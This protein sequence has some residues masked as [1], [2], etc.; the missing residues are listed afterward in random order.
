MDSCAAALLA[1]GKSSRMGEDK[2]SLRLGNRTL[3]Q[4]MSHLLNRA[5]LEKIYI[6]RSD[7]IPDEFPGHGPLSGVHAVLHHAMEHHTHL[8]FV[9][10]D[11]PCLTSA[12]IGGLMNAPS[13]NA[14]VHYTSYPMPFR[15]AVKEQWY[16]LADR[17][18]HRAKDVS[19]KYFQS[20]I[21]N[22]LVLPVDDSDAHAFH[23]INTSEEWRAFKKGEVL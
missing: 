20:Q 17:L 13:D 18:L 12:L 23:N 22:T 21:E 11:M 5:G 9:P 14:L 8:I 1:G 6:S 15:L 4:H 16:A 10:I 19:I 7:I 3:L 2:S